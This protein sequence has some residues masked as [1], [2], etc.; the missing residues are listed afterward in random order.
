MMAHLDLIG[1]F[2]V[3]G[4]LLLSLMTMNVGIQETTQ[5]A[6]MEEVAMGGAQALGSTIEA[7]VRKIG[8]NVPELV[9]PILRAQTSNL[10]FLADVDEDGSPDTVRIWVGDTSEASGTPNPND[11][12]LHRSINGIEE[13]TVPLGLT[14]LT[15]RYYDFRGIVTPQRKKIRR[16]EAQLVVQSTAPTDGGYAA[17]AW[18]LSVRPRN[19]NSSF[20][21]EQ[22]HLSGS[23]F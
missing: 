11:L 22:Y 1:S 10:R 21:W 5:W 20:D 2:V 6:A 9:T 23:E 12:I 13:P 18:D 8:L 15:F 16:I 3:G 7:D 19:V 17:A 4:L 14:Q